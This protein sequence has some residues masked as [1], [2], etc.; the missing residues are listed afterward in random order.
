VAAVTCRRLVATS[1]QRAVSGFDSAGCTGASGFEG[2]VVGC[3]GASGFESVVVGTSLAHRVS[4][5]SSLVGTSC[6]RLGRSGALVVGG[7]C[8]QGTEGG[9]VTTG[10]GK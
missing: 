3:T 1:G 9:F 6:V 8:L 5:H 4:V 2:V 7:L 10:D